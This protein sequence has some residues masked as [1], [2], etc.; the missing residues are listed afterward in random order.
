MDAAV[1]LLDPSKA[2]NLKHIRKQLIRMEDTITF[3]LIERV[4]F[5]LNGTVYKPGAVKIPNSNLSF[6]DWTLREREKADSLIRRYQSPDE[7]PF[8]P[9]A[10]LKS[11][12]Q[13]LTYPKILHRNNIN[14][15]D[16]IKIYF[17]EKVLPS[18]CLDFGREDRGEQAENYGSTVT[19]DIQCLQTISR[20]IHFGK[21]VAES[22]YM[23]D[24]QGF[25]TMIKAGDRIA[26]GKAITKPEVEQQ[27]LERIRLKSRTYSTDPSE[28]DDPEPKIN[29]DAVVAMYRDFV[30]PFTKE[31]EIEYLMQ[32]LSDE[33]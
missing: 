2:L 31:V 21:W 24:P 17:I 27:V 19:T 15:N 29:V 32:R 18:I 5:P 9:D 3:Q 11:I 26:I 20:R 1:D 23:E 6:L 30:I 16:K 13:P 28:P 33:H 10:L 22:K 4:Q 8:F 14:L 25:A 12:L 7:H